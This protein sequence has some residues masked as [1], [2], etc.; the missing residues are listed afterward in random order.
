MNQIDNKDKQ[1]NV[2][3]ANSTQ[4]NTDILYANA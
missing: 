1:D 2:L 4:E 3:N